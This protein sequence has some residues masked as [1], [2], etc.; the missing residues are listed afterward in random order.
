MEDMELTNTTRRRK[1]RY[2]SLETTQ[3]ALRGLDV[4]IT[5][6][7]MVFL[8]IIRVRWQWTFGTNFVAAGVGLCVDAAAAAAILSRLRRKHSLL[9]F[10]VVLCQLVVLALLWISIVAMMYASHVDPDRPAGGVWPDGRVYEFPADMET[11]V[12]LGLRSANAALGFLFI[13]LEGVFWIRA[14]RARAREEYG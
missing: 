8:I 13:G 4:C 5:V 1:W 11:K 14:R 9:G 7:A 3:L 2:D 10:C 6:A 12:V